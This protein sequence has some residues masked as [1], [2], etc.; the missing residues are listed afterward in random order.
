MLNVHS[1]LDSAEY[2]LSAPVFYSKKE[3]KKMR[4]RRSGFLIKKPVFSH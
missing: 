3:Y 4:L 2:L 1:T